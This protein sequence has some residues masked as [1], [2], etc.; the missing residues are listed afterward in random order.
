MSR[1]CR[2]SLRAICGKWGTFLNARINRLLQRFIM[3]GSSQNSRR[4]SQRIWPVRSWLPL[5]LCLLRS[6]SYEW[7]CGDHFL[8]TVSVPF[9][10]G[11]EDGSFT[12][13]LIHALSRSGV[14]V[15]SSEANRRLEAKILAAASESVGYRID[16]QKIKGKIEKNIVANEAR[17]HL[18]VEVALYSSSSAEPLWGPYV[19]S[20]D[21]DFDYVDGDSYQQL[22]FT[23]KSGEQVV[24]LPFSLGQLESQEAAQAAANRPLY[25]RLV[26][27]IV[28]SISCAW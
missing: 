20:A 28:D 13:A 23:N 25:N 5:L 24:V 14:S 1:T 8:R 6:R 22:T 16:P 9:V 26:Q 11:D 15:V 10:T 12:A 17:R 4:A 18:S 21:A 27:K 7:Q 3:R 2:R 19:I